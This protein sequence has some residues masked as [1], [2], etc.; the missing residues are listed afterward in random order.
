MS[1]EIEQV[2]VEHSVRDVIGILEN[3]PVQPDLVGQIT[4]VQI[5]NRVSIA[6]LSIERALKF[7]ITRAGGP[8]IAKHHLGKQLRELARHEPEAVDFL[9]YAFEA[10]VRHYRFNSNAANG[11]HLKSLEA[12]LDVVASDRAFQDLRYWE[13]RQSPDELLLRRLHLALH[14]ELLRAVRELLRGR[15]PTETVSIRVERAV[16]QAMFFPPVLAYAPGSPE[17][18]SVK[19]YLKWRQGFASWRDALANAVQQQFM[20]G[21]D[22]ASSLVA[23]A[24]RELLEH[25]DPAVSYFAGTLDMLPRQP[26]DVTPPVEWIGTPVH[27]RGI[28]SAPSGAELGEIERRWDGLWNIVPFQSGQIAVVAKATSQT[29]AR[30]Y[31]ATLFVRD[32][33]VTLNGEKRRSRIV[34]TDETFIERDQARVGY[35]EDPSTREDDRIHEVIFWDLEHGLKIDDQVKIRARSGYEPRLIYILQGVVA[36]VEGHVVYLSGRA[37]DEVDVHDVQ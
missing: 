22:F 8:L 19:L 33:E 34:A 6:H 23:K 3:E 21:D 20:I 35:A 32:A 12:Y 11:T 30:C 5:M 13:L 31:L 24:Y 1:V 29:D 18:G 17:E 25:S 9:N 28:V 36:N 27:Q 10:A 26:R 4:A 14:M 15:P 7:L 16:E 37:S 2:I